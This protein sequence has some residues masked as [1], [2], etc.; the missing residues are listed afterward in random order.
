MAQVN[1]SEQIHPE[2][3]SFFPDEFYIYIIR[4]PYSFSWCFLQI[5]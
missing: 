5:G 4:I 1:I 2:L 3:F